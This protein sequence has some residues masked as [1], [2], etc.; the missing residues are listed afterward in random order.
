M[1]A[2]A[3]LRAERGILVGNS[4]SGNLCKAQRAFFVDFNTLSAD[5]LSLSNK[6]TDF[7][8]HMEIL[9]GKELQDFLHVCSCILSSA[10]V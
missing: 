10:M 8:I 4:L 3:P 5:V 6:L 7:L 2:A 9:G 1:A